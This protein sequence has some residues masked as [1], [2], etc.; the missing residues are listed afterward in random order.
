MTD[1]R[2][3]VLGPVQAVRDGR[4]VPVPAGRRRAVLACLL[5][6]AGRPVAADSLIDAAWREDLPDEPR[7]ALHTVVSR[8]RMALGADTLVSDAAGY[9]L[10][11]DE[12]AV[13]AH[14]F[15]SLRTRARS[16]P[17]EEA[18]AL[19]QEALALWRGPAYEEY[20][21]H[22]FTAPEAQRLERLRLDAIEEHAAAAADAGE[23][24]EAI[25]EIE[26]LLVDHPFRE[27][28]VELL[29]TTLYRAGRQADALARCRD[30]R[31]TLSQELGLD[32][33]PVLR[34]LEFRILGHDV[35]PGTGRRERLVA[36]A[37]LD[38][39][40][41]FFGRETATADLVAAVASNRLVTV[42]GV[43][44]VGKTRLV[45]QSLPALGE[46]L[47][48]PI[49]VVEFAQV[50]PGRVSTAVADALR[51]S[52]RARGVA[53]DVLEYL[54]IA[55]ALLVL[56]N[57]EHLRTEVAAFAEAVVPRC[58]WVRLV[59]TSRRRLGLASERVVP[60]APFP[61]ADGVGHPTQFG[62]NPAVQL[63]S[64]RV[65][66][67]RPSFAVT[68]ENIGAV[69]EL[70]RRVDGLPLGL[71]LAASRAA[72]FGV[73]PVLR[74]F[75]ADPGGAPLRDL[76]GVVEWSARLLTT[77]QRRLLGLVAVF[78]GRFGPEDAARVAV[79]LG[80]WE[81]ARAVVGALE[82]LVEAHLVASDGPGM[83]VQYR[84]LALVR[85]FARQQL[86]ESG[87]EEAARHAHAEWVREV[88]DQALGEWISG[89]ATVASGR[90]A[91][92]GP[93]AIAALRWTM[94]AG[95]L[96]VAASIAGAI[97]LCLHW[98]PGVELGDLVVEVA[99]RCAVSDPGPRRALGLAAGAMT[100]AERGDLKRT[101]DLAAAALDSS[102][103]DLPRLLACMALAVSTFYSAEH[104]ES[105]AWLDR[106]AELS[107][108]PAAYQVEPH[109]TRALLDRYRD[110]LAAA[111]AS[112][113]VALVGAAASRAEG[114]RA[115][116]LY[117][118]GE[119]EARD[120]PDHGAALFR[121]AA[122]EAERI[123]AAH[124]SQVSRLALFAALVRSERHGE[125]LRL[126]LP[127]LQ[128]L[129][130][131]GTWPQIWTTLRIAAE[132]LTAHE[133]RE[134]AA[135]LLAAARTAPTAPPLVGE[136]VTRY[137]RLSDQLTCH[138]GVPV[139]TRIGELAAGTP[140]AQV[141]GRA[142]DLLSDL[143]GDL[144]RPCPARPA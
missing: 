82:E 49:A 66:R 121:E 99:Q 96:D 74:W 48:V 94:D 20:A 35:P 124:V 43:G 11:V 126:V 60:L 1:L 113:S 97:T 28:A 87:E 33:S 78:A 65:R 142:M 32:P 7:A 131:A 51:L 92:V 139:V 83:E 2:F 70:C 4:V 23:H 122:E 108:L 22:D 57:C 36:P 29:V 101:R 37:W 144:A 141:L 41:A 89:N 44:G 84:M 56:D 73:G 68:S 127:L 136:D 138:L 5:V 137:G 91:R 120:D 10:A 77:E 90:L 98:L 6:H 64:D 110:D 16:A 128:D 109:I 81:E 3:G 38:T 34:D 19:L 102:E 62:G 67:L 26:A 119:I 106:A 107:D 129:R 88:V 130:R 31:A 39:S 69:V 52:P 55:H 9:A 114:A 53:D 21:D 140:R 143:G 115:F 134:D 118:S 95:R 117:A 30:Y 103:T 86:T 15:E 50:Q 125:A 80:P 76:R 17:P 59:V 112:V 12:Q 63:F 24:A 135:F 40:T 123:G 27:R 79:R 8:L 132:L 116:A 93:D 54:S 105:A 61:M 25:A 46:R 42:T 13:D 133:R 111:R 45:A 18:A 47:Q 85:S 75:G 72:T 14:R 58:P 100:S 71:E 104:E